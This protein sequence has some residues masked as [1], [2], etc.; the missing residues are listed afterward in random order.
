MAKSGW[1]RVLRALVLC[2]AFVVA[3]TAV[4][5]D[6]VKPGA[7]PVLGPD[8]GFLV[9]A[10]DS[11]WALSTVRLTQVGHAFGAVAIPGIPEGGGTM[12]LVLPAGRYRWQQVE[13]GGNYYYQAPKKSPEYEFEV[14]AGRINYVGDFVFRPLG[15]RADMHMAN[16]GLRALDWLRK[17]HPK[18]LAANRF[19]YVGNFPDP[20]PAFYQTARAASATADADLDRL[21]PPPA[22]G[23]LPVDI[24]KLWRPSRVRD[25]E[26]APS[27]KLLAETVYA[28]G[29]WS[30]E[31]VDFAAGSAERVL[32]P[33]SLPVIGL[34]WL[35]DQTLVATLGDDRGG[36]VEVIHLREV[37]GKRK[38]EVDTVPFPG[39]VLSRIAGTRVL[40]LSY[41]SQG[42]PMVHRLDLSSAQAVDAAPHG[43]QNRLNKQV[44]GGYYFVADRSGEIRVVLVRDKETRSLWYG[45]GKEFAKVL[46]LD[47][48]DGFDPKLLSP[49]GALIYGLSDQGRGQRD[50]VVFD[51]VS[52]TMT[53]TLY[54]KPGV[55]VD[56]ILHD[57]Q[58]NPT[59]VTYTRGGQHIVEYFDAAASAFYARLQGAFP[60]RTVLLLDRDDAGQRYVLAVTGSDKPL[61]VYEYDRTRNAASLVDDGQPWLA[62]V[63]L[64]PAQVLHATG[65]DG[66]PIEA[67]LTL[68][69]HRGDK[70]PVVVL[71]HG[72]PVGVADTLDFDPEVQFLASLGYAVLQV[73]F[74]GSDGYGTAHRK[75]GWAGYGTLIE[76]DIHAALAVAL[77]TQPLDGTRVCA[78]G[79][80]YGGYSSLVSA[81]RWPEQ[82]K[83]VVTISGVSDRPLRFTASDSVRTES[84]RKSLI[85]ALG[86]PNTQLDAMIAG[87]PLYHA[88]QLRVPVMIV[89][90]TEDERVD[91]EHAR[92]LVRALN[93]V[94]RPPVVIPL[95]GEGHGINTV[96][97]R[98]R[99]YP[100]IAAFL[101][102]YL[103]G[104][105]AGYGAP[106][107]PKESAADKALPVAKD[108]PA[109]PAGPA[110]PP[111]GG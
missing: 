13:P 16:R 109:T 32:S 38:V 22:T 34:Q 44:P 86:D 3:G 94:D 95:I 12:L 51:P 108:A 74:R 37:G 61:Q 84:L 103:G 88:D 39:Q 91:F 68:P 81:I 5:V 79:T 52:R 18:V 35:D 50:A 96:E 15:M 93:L 98:L 76:E 46:D 27:G 100:V 70:A 62:D 8:E 78:M 11:P 87:S 54:S 56:A 102:R 20:F 19:E 1:G 24:E 14:R 89:H 33:P 106:A 25:V 41:S 29:K 17:Y 67:F 4:A 47:E 73:N 71:A 6:K 60:G 64:A 104:A 43:F 63:P 45:Q 23:T 97:N 26:L 48:E 111:P 58:G 55:D 72:G 57:G 7:V 59:G 82:Y 21:A 53:R 77:A 90:G 30:V 105:G 65:T 75:A 66:L 49:D 110:S 31:L 80:S 2:A 10:V 85:K 36:R 101:A 99:T 69:L 42:E 28:N 40:F 83:C 9:A 92:R 107:T